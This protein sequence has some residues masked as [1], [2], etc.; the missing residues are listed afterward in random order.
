MG[1]SGTCT[2]TVCRALC[3]VSGIQG[4]IRQALGPLGVSWGREG[5]SRKTIKDQRQHNVT[6]PLHAAVT[7]L[8]F[9]YSV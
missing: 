3:Y 6:I 8:L 5:M 7:C 9:K 1:S 2:P 4:S